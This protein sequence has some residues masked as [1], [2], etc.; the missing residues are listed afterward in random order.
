MRRGFKGWLSFPSLPSRAYLWPNGE[1]RAYLTTILACILAFSLSG[2]GDLVVNRAAEGALRP[3]PTTVNFGVVSIGK[4]ASTTVSLLNVSLA[5]VEVTQLNLTGQP[6]SVDA[7]ILP[8]TIASGGTYTLNVQFNPAAAGMATGQLVIASNS[9]TDGTAVIALTGTG[10]PSIGTTG[11]G[12]AALSALSCSSGAMAGPGTD[13]CTVT[14]TNS[15]PSGGLSVNLSS[16][17]SV[18]TVPSNVTVPESAISAGFTATVDSVVT[19]QAAMMTASAGSVSKNFTLQ[20]NVAI[21]AL[22][23]NATRVA[24]GDVLV[25]TPATQPMTLTST[26]T[27]PV[28]INGATLTGMGFTMSGAEFPATLNPSQEMTLNLGFDP[29][30]V[31]AATGQLTITSNSSTN[32]TSVIGL[33]GTGTAA[34]GATTY[35]VDNCVTVGND[36]NNGTSTSTPWLTINK[37]NKS[38]FNPGDSILFE[39]TCTWREQ[40]TVPSSG[41]AGSSITFGAY[42]TGTAPMISGADL[43]TTWARSAGFLYYAPYSTAP[44]QIFEDGVRL[45]QNTVGTGSLTAGQWYLDTANSR[46]WL[47]TTTGDNPNGHTME[48]S[49]RDYAIN[50]DAKNYVTVENIEI[51]ETNWDCMEVGSGS[52]N[53]ILSNNTMIYCTS[54]LGSAG[55]ESAVVVDAGSQGRITGNQISYSYTG[56]KL[57][58][59]VVGSSVVNAIQ[60][61][62]NTI[63]QTGAACILI[64]NGASNVTAEYNAL[65]Y[66][67]QS[68]D[69][70][71]GIDS[72]A[73]TGSPVGAVNVIRYNSSTHCGPATT[74][75]AAYMLDYGSQPTQLY[76]NLGA[77]NTN[78]CINLISTGHFIYGNTC[79]HDMEGTS[80]SGEMGLYDSGSIT[81]EDN[82]FVAESSKPIIYVDPSSGV[83]DALNYNLYYGG[84]LTPLAWLGTSYNFSNWQT[85]SGQDAN[86]RDTDP[87]FV[88]A[89]SSQFWLASSSPAIDA[90]LNLGATYDLGPDP[91]STWPS[92]IILDN[93]NEFGS[94]WEIGAYV[95]TQTSTPPS[96]GLLPRE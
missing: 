68:Y 45:T 26:G 33:T 1:G 67:A 10:T 85:N 29:T 13:A 11:T 31:G 23:I 8:I 9:S 69:D 77:F 75:C 3:Q 22:S 15:A 57:T 72:I 62:H 16:S 5:P 12:P 76:D 51:T 48:M 27:V 4:T 59:H 80:V 40:L 86:S 63:T 96:S 32:G 58:Q 7:G 65:S 37:V 43:I 34:T 83:G 73:G 21:L 50:I 54:P 30:A 52:T 49:Q 93:Q 56:I 87:K 79:Y 84:S 71:A 95:Y 17:N 64:G 14:L 61:D 91:A 28:T 60:V 6:F 2:C 74:R 44:N 19:P 78:G 39:S 53:F 20:L 55:W 46:I 92:D 82:I 89:S 18:V 47:Y 90:G 36:A 81:A 70:T 41:S 25:N 38:N 66:C 42:G 35:Y 24:F 94:G 88:N